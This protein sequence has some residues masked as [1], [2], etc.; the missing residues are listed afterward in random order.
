[1]EGMEIDEKSNGNGEKENGHTLR[2]V[3]P[4]ESGEGL[5]FAPKDWPN[6]G[7]TWGWRVGKRVAATGHFLDRYL[8]LPPRIC[9]GGLSNRK[10]RGF[11]SK[12]SVERF[13]RETY[14][15]ADLN[16][17]FN[18]FSWR[19]PAKASSLSGNV[20][21]RVFS[22][23]PFEEATE[24]STPDCDGVSLSLASA[25]IVA[26]FYV[27]RLLVQNMEDTVTSSVNHCIALDAGYYCRRC[28]ARTDLVPHVMR[29]LQTSESVDSGDE[30]KKL[31]SVGFCILRG[32]QRT[33][34]KELLNRVEAAIKKFKFGTILEDMRNA[35]EDILAISK[36]V[37][38][39]QN[40]I[41][42]RTDFEKI[43]DHNSGLLDA[44]PLSFDH[45]GEAVKLQEEID[46]VLEA[47]KK[48]QEYEYEIAEE[49]LHAQ[50]RYLQNLYQQLDKEKS[51][52]AHCTSNSKADALLSAVTRRVDQIKQEVRKF[53]DM[54]EVANGFGRTSK[55]TLQEYFGLEIEI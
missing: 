37:S 17:F 15:D 19:I 43:L 25:V 13:L 51:Q 9:R 6:P 46:E 36:D 28:D 3:D 48:S 26:V 10:K 45:Q 29:I 52:L 54:K 33:D 53:K 11:A 23:L 20:G 14:P 44:V 39:V 12:L 55:I 32:S 4:D 47:L 42:E 38:P 35:E 18:S 34:A 24:L 31:L 27:P 16:A 8:Y 22:T 7:D 21:R 49:R 1:M 5:P 50:K 30:K 41:A 40:A 2:P